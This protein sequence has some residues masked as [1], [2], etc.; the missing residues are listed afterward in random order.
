[1]FSICV[2]GGSNLM[3]L[4]IHVKNHHSYMYNVYI[5]NNQNIEFCHTFH[6][7][8]CHLESLV[9]SHQTVFS[10]SQQI[11]I[12]GMFNVMLPVENIGCVLIKQ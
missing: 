12:N 3:T 8:K 4:K 10:F 9:I 7:V 2:Y 1:M 5:Y 6:S 11:S